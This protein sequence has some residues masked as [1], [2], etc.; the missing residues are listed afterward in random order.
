[1]KK[2][3]SFMVFEVESI[4]CL[5]SLYSKAWQ[6]VFEGINYLLSLPTLTHYYYYYY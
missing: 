6:L 4:K 5:L 3:W 1:M 2:V